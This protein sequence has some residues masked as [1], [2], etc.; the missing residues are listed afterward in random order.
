MTATHPSP[1]PNLLADEEAIALRRRLS[2]INGQVLGI[3]RMITAGRP[4]GDVLIQIA[5]AQAALRE[6]ALRVLACHTHDAVTAVAA[7]TTSPDEAAAGINTLVALLTR[8]G[9]QSRFA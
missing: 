6:V 3:E 2:R 4:C 9:G 5:A 8:A 7:T 1:S